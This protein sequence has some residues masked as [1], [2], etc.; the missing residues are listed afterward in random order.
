MPWDCA[1][2]LGR[3]GRQGKGSGPSRL[4]ATAPLREPIPD[5]RTRPAQAKTPGW[6]T[7]KRTKAT[8][9]GRSTAPRDNVLLTNSKTELPAFPSCLRG[10]TRLSAR[11]HPRPSPQ[12]KLGT[13][14]TVSSS[15]AEAQRRGGGE[16]KR[17]RYPLQRVAGEL[18]WESQFSAFPPGL[19]PRLCASAREQP[20]RPNAPIHRP[21]LK[22]KTKPRKKN[23]EAH[24]GH[25]ERPFHST[26]RQRIAHEIQRPNSP[27][28]LRALRAFVVPP[29]FPAAS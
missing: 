1:V 4:S 14:P 11:P 25:E 6:I 16:K 29:A 17:K 26:P 10:A 2:S 19:S 5:A 12:A 3:F 8:K 7:T 27:H 18:P 13:R 15:R 21:R 28:S 22:P 23:H 24:E 20:R 9:K